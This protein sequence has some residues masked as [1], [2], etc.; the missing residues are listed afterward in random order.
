MVASRRVFYGLAECRKCLLYKELQFSENIA[1][2]PKH[3]AAGK[4]N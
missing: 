4:V 1:L 2:A 3:F